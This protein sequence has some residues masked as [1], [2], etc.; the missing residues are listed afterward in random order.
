MKKAFYWLD[1]VGFLVLAA[2]LA[3]YG[4]RGFR[5]AAGMGIAAAALACWVTARRQLGASFSVTPQ[6]RRLVTSGLYSKFRN[7]IYLF[8][9]LA[10]LG[11][12]I[13]W[14][15]WGGFVYLALLTPVQILR[16]R[17]ERAVLE[18]AFGEE[19]RAYKDGTWF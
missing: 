1:V 7:P 16:I 3:V 4:R 2:L 6:A 8:G 5:F 9:Q 15:H 11:L 18:Q 10:F 12:A 17:K 14:G 13:A 19:Y